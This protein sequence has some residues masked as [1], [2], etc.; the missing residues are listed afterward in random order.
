MMCKIESSKAL[1][2]AEKMY[3]DYLKEK[4]EPESINESFMEV[5]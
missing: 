5:N 3:D 1:E 2:L 4:F